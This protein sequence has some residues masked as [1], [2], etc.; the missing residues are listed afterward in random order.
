VYVEFLQSAVTPI[1]EY[2]LKVSADFLLNIKD[3]IAFACLQQ[4]H[5][6]P[7][8]L[9]VGQGKKVGNRLFFRSTAKNLSIDSQSECCC[10]VRAFIQQHIKK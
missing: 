10:S 8:G 7:I 3:G 2:F 9:D 1:Y 5:D 6:F 4:G